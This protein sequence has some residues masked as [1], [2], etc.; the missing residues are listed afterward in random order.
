[1]NI[2]LKNKRL[3]IS[4]VLSSSVLC[5]LIGQAN[6]WYHNAYKTVL[7]FMKMCCISNK[8]VSYSVC[9]HWRPIICFGAAIKDNWWMYISCLEPVW[10]ISTEPSLCPTRLQYESIVAVCTRDTMIW[11]T[12]QCWCDHAVML[13]CRIP[14]L[15]KGASYD[16]AC[17]PDSCSWQCV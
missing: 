4:F 9:A 3:S 1:M 15:V 8:Y 12:N 7:K 6:C 2:H 10:P 5:I 13:F 16:M 17:R 11:M 14:L